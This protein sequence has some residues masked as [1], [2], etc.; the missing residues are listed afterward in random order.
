M[1]HRWKSGIY[2]LQ[3]I[4]KGSV[5]KNKSSGT[6]IQIWKGNIYALFLALHICIFQTHPCCAN[7]YLTSH[8]I[9]LMCVKY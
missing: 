3:I 6:N 5:K 2:D 1:I 4:L 7:I 9:Q 8:F